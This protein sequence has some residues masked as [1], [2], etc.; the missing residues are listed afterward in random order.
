MG[1]YSRVIDKVV[2][3]PK[4]KNSGL[5]REVLETILDIYNEAT[6]DVLVN[7]G[8]VDIGDYYK[9]ELVKIQPRIHVLRGVEYRSRRNYKLRAYLQP[10][11]YQIVEDFYSELEE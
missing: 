4:I 1:N 8:Y 9:A 7:E 10:R 6:F 2:E 3:N 11:T 5:K